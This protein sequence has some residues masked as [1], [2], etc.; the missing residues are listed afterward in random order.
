M[1]GLQLK[2]FDRE[3]VARLV[4]TGDPRSAAVA[5]Y[6]LRTH[7][8][9]RRWIGVV[10]LLLPVL[11]V[12]VDA[13][14]MDADPRGSMSAYYHASSRDLFVGGLCVTAGFLLTYMSARKR[15]YDYWLSTVAGVMVLVVAF[16]PTARELP[17]SA[18]AGAEALPVSSGSCQRVAEGVPACTALQERF[19][20]ET[21]KLV[22][23]TAAGLFVVLLVGLC[24]VFAL[25]EFGYGPGAARLCGDRRDVRA[26]RRAVRERGVPLWRYLLS[27]LPAVP[28][29]PGRSRPAAPPPRRRVLAYAAWAGL[30]VVGGVWALTGPSVAVPGVGTF[31]R[32]YVG[33]LVA[34]VAFAL[35]WLTVSGD[36]RVFR[37]PRRR[38][39]GGGPD[40]HQ[41][42][43]VPAGGAGG[44]SS[45]AGR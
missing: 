5:D 3:A 1:L 10:G 45:R 15:T 29:P 21:V 26:V 43:P 17:P 28:G 20:E 9:M 37:R 32:T 25:R 14:L 19:G 12:V 42:V 18:P 44:A 33:E 38:P 27:G 7:L 8:G 41:R 2:T 40:R 30:I 24:T 16:L 34:F 31:G 4:E 23:G 13:A 39:A 22:H 35:A 11:L 36:W 6:L